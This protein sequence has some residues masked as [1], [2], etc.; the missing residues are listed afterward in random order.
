MEPLDGGNFQGIN[1]SMLQQLIKS[2]NSGVTG[3]QP[4]A[5]SYVSQFTR[6]G[7]DTGP[8]QKLLA[9][10][11]WA[12]AQQPM[13]NRRYSLASHQPSGDFSDGWTEEGASTLFYPTTAAAKGAGTADARQMQAYLDAHDWSGI[14]KELDAMA[15]NGDDPDYMAAFFSQLGPK[16]LYA[17]SWYAQGGPSSDAANEQ[18]VQQI[19]G[20]GLATASYEMPLTMNFLQ[21][22]GPTNDPMATTQVLPGGWDS[23][24]LAPFLTEGEFSDQWLQTI[25]PTVLYLRSIEAGALLPGGYDAIFQAMASNPSFAAKFYQ[26]NSGPAERLHDRPRAVPHPRERPGVRQ[27]PR[28]GHDRAAGHDGHQAVHC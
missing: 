2:L 4:L 14:Q 3:A 6:L 13:L 5:N 26:Q 24:A 1:P 12:S 8:I 20:S 7:L 15:Q 10:Y 18:E 19:V 11:A 16:G 21:G 28:G 22:I 9:D 17:L 27:V 25:A 23:G